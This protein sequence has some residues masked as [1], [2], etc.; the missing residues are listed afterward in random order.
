MQRC[1]AI[2]CFTG[3]ITSHSS[4]AAPQHDKVDMLHTL[5]LRLPHHDVIVICLQ[6]YW[7]GVRNRYFLAAGGVDMMQELGSQ[8]GL[9][10]QGEQNW[11]PV[12]H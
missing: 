1:R 8:Y 3:S 10:V 9:P 5:F 4:Q 2:V 7:H 6:D 12:A 11:V